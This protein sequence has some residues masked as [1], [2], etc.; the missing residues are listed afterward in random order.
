MQRIKVIIMVLLFVCLILFPAF[1]MASGSGETTLGCINEP[2]HM[3][4]IS[5]TYNVKGWALD[6]E[7]V[8]KVEILI[9]KNV[10]GEADYG[11]LRSDIGSIYTEF[12][13]NYCGF[14]YSFDTTK[15]PSGEHSIF[16]RVINNKDE[17]KTFTGTKIIVSNSLPPVWNVDSPRPSETI[18]GQYRISGWFLDGD[19][20]SSLN[21]TIDG[22]PYGKA[23]YGISRDDIFSEYPG[24]D[25]K[26]A[27]FVYDLD[28]SLL[29]DGS[30]TLIITETSKE[31]NI[32]ITPA[33]SFE[34]SNHDS[35][36]GTDNADKEE[37]NE[38]TLPNQADSLSNSAGEL[39]LSMLQDSPDPFRP[40]KTSC[41]LQYDVSQDA[42]VQIKIFDQN[43][44]LI[45]TLFDGSVNAGVQ[46]AKWDGTD[47]NNLPVTSGTYSYVITA[48]NNLGSVQAED[49]VTVDFSP[50][51]SKGVTITYTLSEASYVSISIFDGS[52]K[53]IRTLQESQLQPAG[54]NKAVWDG[55]DSSGRI[56]PDGVYTYKISAVDLIGLASNP[57]SGKI[58]VERL[59]P[60]ITN[61][62]DSPD[63]FSPNGSNF[64][65]IKYT[66]SENCLVEIK[67]LGPN[68]EVIKS[69]RSV[70]EAAGEHFVVWDGKDEYGGICSG[71]VYTYTIDAADSFKKSAVTSTGIISL[72]LIPPVITKDIATPNPLT[73]GS[74]SYE[75]I[76]YYLS[77]DA[78]I[79]VSIYDNNNQLI[80]TVM[81]NV[82]K[83]EGANSAIWDGKNSSGSYVTDGA[84]KYVINATDTVGQKAVPAMGIINVDVKP[85]IMNVSHTPEPFDPT[86]ADAP[87]IIK[88]TISKNAVVIIDIYDNSSNLVK[89]LKRTSVKEGVN[90]CIWDGKNSLGTIVPDGVY[91]Y[92]LITQNA[93]GRY[94]DAITGNITI[95]TSVPEV[96]SLA[97]LPNPFEPNGSNKA[98]F[99]YNL[100]EEAKVTITLFDSTGKVIA[101]VENTDLKPQGNNLSYWGGR[102][103]SG[104]IVPEGSY[105]YKLSAADLTGH[106][107]KPFTGTLQV[108]HSNPIIYDVSDN[109]DPF[110]PEK[111]S[112][113]I[114]FS[115]SEKGTAQVKVFDKN[116]ALVK[117][118]FND[119]IV[120]GINKVVWDGKNSNNTIVESGIYTYKISAA[121][122]FG[123]IAETV[124]DTVYVDSSAPIVSKIETNPNPF[125]PNGSNAVAISYNISEGAQC[126]IEI[127][128]EKGTVIAVLQ[129]DIP[130]LSGSNSSA[131]NGMIET[132]IAQD[133][134]YTIRVTAKDYSGLT[135]TGTGALSVEGANPIISG[136]SDNPD[137]FNP[138]VGSINTIQ[139]NISEKA[140]VSI[141][142]YDQSGTLVKQ[143]FQNTVSKGWHT[144][145][146]NGSNSS[147]SLAPTGIYTYKIDATDSYGK[148]AN[149]GIGTITSDIENPQ[150]T[151]VT[152][153]PNPFEP[154]GTNLA[155]FS[156]R[157]SENADVTISLIN[158]NNTVV[159]TISTISLKG[160][161]SAFWDGK[162][163]FGNIVPDGSYEFLLTAKDIT[164][165]ASQS[166]KGALTI[167]S[168]S[169]YVFNIEALPNP[170][171]PHIG[172]NGG[173]L[174]SF[175]VSENSKVNVTILDGS[176]QVVKELAKDKVCFTNTRIQVGWDGCDNAST[177]IDN[178]IY[179]YRIE[180]I[181]SFGKKSDP[182]E[183]TISVTG[184]NPFIQI[185]SIQPQLFVPD[186]TAKS[187]L[188]YK[189]ESDGDIKISIYGENN[190]FIKEILASTRQQAGEHTISWDGKNSSNS[191]V[192]D[193]TFS[194]VIQ[195]VSAVNKKAYTES[196][197]FRLDRTPP[198]I[199]NNS[200]NP[201]PF[202]PAMHIATR[203]TFTL[204]EE[205][206]TTIEI[207]SN[208]NLIRTL[209]TKK[210]RSPGT[211][212]ADWDGK[213]SNGELCPVGSYTYKI[214]AK[215]KAGLEAAPITDTIVIEKPGA[216]ITDL[217][218]SPDPYI[219]DGVT[220]NIIS[221][222]IT[223]P[224][225]LSYTLYDPNKRVC[226]ISTGNYPETIEKP[227]LYKIIWR[228]MTIAE[229]GKEKTIFISGVY[230]YVVEAVDTFGTKETVEGTLTIEI[231]TPEITEHG[232]SPNP[233]VPTRTN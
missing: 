129:K 40:G 33:I 165:N 60:S 18:S 167:D 172:G 41:T 28:T 229:T 36:K 102:N 214:Y 46:S 108:I 202:I 191:F 1:S 22:K 135:G 211:N 7:G 170:Y 97:V 128:D 171:N 195:A 215:D 222:N 163:N 54:V 76:S 65:T 58:V 154:N 148:K 26:Y 159:K 99:F 84:Y 52:G 11:D 149:T 146:W 133:G 233:F 180:A 185:T 8:S 123:K 201:N 42:T 66:I 196:G 21:L 48:S 38:N 53:L 174:V 78:L 55:K 193:G 59:I 160:I 194:Y 37:T 69:L 200:V 27:G 186:G 127:L 20:V 96:R 88:Y 109:P 161:N 71:G 197:A 56:V 44:K 6:I 226:G 119:S 147:G 90:T 189:I 10:I 151:E 23:L 131:W 25:N 130:Q 43:R 89:N 92:S 17:K 64:N 94:S 49:T 198:D 166:A 169:P 216:L 218:D 72:D 91:T 203:M 30:H 221:F 15:V 122:S 162:D 115:S 75:T 132:G 80:K 206:E 112:V 101:V 178:G 182:F 142:L 24:Y 205:S 34:I 116:G 143:V 175:Y 79:S 230:R 134:N 39:A 152:V 141:N 137:P 81:T 35:G 111:S 95:D 199:I 62:S 124:S 164:G 100:S 179:T 140:V 106:I 67:V 47:D 93:Q 145:D 192:P 168:K 4:S 45:K 153:S 103:S 14:H 158:S 225:T 74:E 156:F 63:P 157:I 227:K 176:K 19:K 32:T 125:A 98:V 68:S 173:C 5:G 126:T 29:K 223:R 231:P 3:E 209:E 31:G 110:C 50:V 77:E 210:I 120:A 232:A 220:W 150:I 144:A 83:K 113:T 87:A 207:Y 61:V 136:V 104:E 188:G 213:N 155:E 105:T 114:Q 9:D 139:Y 212:T 107:A 184:G 228:V 86:I 2:K 177:I 190:V 224:A 16:L 217:N 57:T 70:Q 13:N 204:S 219:F 117:T 12:N 82:L 85:V 208:N 181:D 121:S 73:P 118:I 138:T 183:G 187:T 51:E